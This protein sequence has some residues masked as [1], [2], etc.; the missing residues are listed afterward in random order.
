MSSDVLKLRK[1]SI[2]F[3]WLCFLAPVIGTIIYMLIGGGVNNPANALAP[4]VWLQNAPVI[5]VS[6]LMIALSDTVSKKGYNL[7][8]KSL[9]GL[10][11]AVSALSMIYWT[12]FIG[13]GR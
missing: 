4:F 8:R 2:I 9:L 11:I 13:S 1:V 12:W 3:A 10:S 7:A 6:V 5:F